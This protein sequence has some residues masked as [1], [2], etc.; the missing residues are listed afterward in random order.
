MSFNEPNVEE[1]SQGIAK[2]SFME[3]EPKQCAASSKQ[4]NVED[5]LVKNWIVLTKIS[6]YHYI[7]EIS[8]FYRL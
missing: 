4:E 7:N 6:C 3:S 2:P 8:T 5:C 1:V